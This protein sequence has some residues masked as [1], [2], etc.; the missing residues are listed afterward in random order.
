MNKWQIC[1]SGDNGSESQIA[2]N[3]ITQLKLIEKALKEE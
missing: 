2:Y 3:R 1:V